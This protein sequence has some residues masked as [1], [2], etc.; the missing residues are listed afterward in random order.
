MQVD[1]GAANRLTGV[2]MGGG[3]AGGDNMTATYN[4][5]SYNVFNVSHDFFQPNHRV[6]VF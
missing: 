3:E 4:F 2:E 6:I 1:L 5:Q